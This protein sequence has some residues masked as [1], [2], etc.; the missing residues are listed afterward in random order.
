MSLAL[1]PLGRS[2]FEGYRRYAI[3]HYA[4][5]K[6]ESGQWPSSG[7]LRR[8]EKEV[9]SLLPDGVDTSGHFIYSIQAGTDD[10]GTVWIHIREE[11]GRTLAWIYDLVISEDFRGKDYG[12]RALSTVETKA[13]ELGAEEM[14]LHV[15]A[16][17]KA[18]VGLYG[19]SDYEA[20][21]IVMAKQI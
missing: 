9:G 3:G 7:A 8:S 19:K 1:E 10:I 17:N 11:N 20:T 14:G 21:S 12:S 2:D 4:R 16:H 15:F 6:V 18:A 13:K 5:E